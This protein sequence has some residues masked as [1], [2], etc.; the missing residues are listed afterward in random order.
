MFK[1]QAVKQKLIFCIYFFPSQGKIRK[2]YA[3]E[4]PRDDYLTASPRRQ[5]LQQQCHEIGADPW[6][7]Y[8]LQPQHGLPN[9]NGVSRSV[10]F[11]HFFEESQIIFFGVLQKG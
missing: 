10:F 2:V 11:F 3:E 7:D 6:P 5:Y 9:H 8:Q 1:K 4:F